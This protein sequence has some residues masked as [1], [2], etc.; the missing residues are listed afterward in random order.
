MIRVGF[1]LSISDGWLGGINYFRNLLWAIHDLP[2]R[3]IQPVIFTCLRSDAGQ[4]K[5]FPDVEIVRSSLFDR[6]TLPWCIRKLLRRI[7]LRDMLL[8]NLLATHGAAVLSH[9]GWIGANARIPAIG[10]IP[11]FQHTHLPEFFSKKEAATRDSEFHRLCRLCSCVLLSSFDAQKD[12]HAMYPECAAKSDVLQF[13][14]T[15]TA[16]NALPGLE[17]LRKRYQFDGDYFLL[18]NQFW[19]HKNHRAVIEALRILNSSGRKVLVL[20]TGGTRDYRQPAYFDL[21]MGYARE[22]GVSDNFRVLGLVSGADLAALMRHS[23]ALINP[24]LFEGWSTTVEEAKSLGKRIILSDIPVHREQN[25]A[26]GKFFYPSDVQTLAEAMW[27]LWSQRDAQEDARLAEQARDALPQRREAFAAKYQEIVLRVAEPYME[28]DASGALDYRLNKLD[29]SLTS[30]PLISVITVCFNATEFIEQCMQSV[31]SQKCDDF[32]YIVI[33]GG[34]TDGTRQIIEK[35]SNRLAYWHSKPDRGLAH[36]FNQG[37]EHS[38]GQWLLFLNSDDY[39]ADN[40]VLGKLAAELRA[41]P[42]SDVVFGQI[43]VVSR[44]AASR[45]IGGPYG[46]PFSWWRFVIVNDVLPHPAAA[47]NRALFNRIGLFREDMSIAVDYEHLLRAGRELKAQYVP[48]L[49]TFMRDGGMSKESIRATLSDG[50]RARIM[51]RALPLS[52]SWLLYYYYFIRSFFGRRLR[53][54]LGQEI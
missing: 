44:D 39:F 31:L 38:N 49:V 19:A 11:D 1:V 16:E 4:F 51:A 26:G 50:H 20:V 13:V 46:R 18:P 48:L 27:R 23:L 24:S 8:E 40:A 30:R 34:S 45:R 12:L 21:L 35:Y 2:G 3:K 7:F 53:R 42:Q 32:E 54:L 28:A 10:W 22:C 47:T 15:V 37:V 29:Q 52:L 41:N 17:D 36:A 6:Y 14:A 33:D 5:D 25:P 9:S 43:M